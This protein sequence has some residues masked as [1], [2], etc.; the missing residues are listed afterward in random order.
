MTDEG[1]AIKFYNDMWN[2]INKKVNPNRAQKVKFL[3]DIPKKDK[4]EEALSGPVKV[5][6]F[7]DG[8]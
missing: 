3:D 5:E 2:K 8:S 6:S 7:N 1:E 4:Y